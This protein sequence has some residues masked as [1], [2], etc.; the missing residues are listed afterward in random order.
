MCSQ[1]KLFSGP[2][3][4]SLL[5]HA[6]L[7]KCLLTCRYSLLRLGNLESLHYHVLALPCSD[8]LFTFQ[9]TP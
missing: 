4:K 8:T 1:V 6:V 9:S 5:V 3:I 2:P 7:R